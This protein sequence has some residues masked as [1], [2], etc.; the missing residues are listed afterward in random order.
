M[1]NHYLFT[2]ITLVFFALL[3]C[4]ATSNSTTGTTNAKPTGSGIAG[5]TSGMKKY[6]G[7]FEFYYDGKTDKVYLLVDKFDQEFIYV[8][9]LAA[10]IGSND[11]G[12][13]RNQLGN[14]RVVKFERVGPKILLVEPN[15]SYRAV[16]K[17]IAEQKAVE[18]A[19]AKSI[20]YGFKM[21][22]EEDGKVLVDATDFFM[23]DAHNVT[24]RLKRAQQ[25]N[26]S[27]KKDLS[28]FYLEKTKNFPENS[29]FEVTLTFTGT[30][31]GGYIRSV[32]PT[33][34]NI[35]VRM[36]HSFVK[37]PDGNYEP[38]RF[39]PRAGFFGVSYYDYA[40]PI[41]EDIE[42]KFIARHR[43][44]KKDP[45]AEMSEAIEPIVYYLDPGTPEPIKSALVEG[46]GWWN[47]AFEAAGY[48]NAFQVKVLPEG[49]DP[50]DVRYNVINWVHR[51]TRGWSY[52]SSVTDPRTGEIIK[53]HVLLG[54]LRVRQ[55]FLIAEALLAPYE[56]GT[57]VPPEMEQMAL[58]RLRQ[59]AAHEVGHTLG[60]AHSYASSAENRASV[61]DYPHP[62][63]NLKEGKI[64][65]SGAYDNKIGEWD[66]VAIT[67][68][69]KN[70]EEGED[71]GQALDDI[72][73]DSFKKG[74]SFLSDQDARPQGGAHPYAHLWD[75]GK[76]AS[77]ELKRV[78]EIR[79]IALAKFG[80]NN[81]RTGDAYASLE[82]V[83]VPLYFFHRYQT[84]AAVK[85]MGGLNYRYALRGDGQLITEIVSAEEQ[86]KALDALLTTISSEQL[87]L[88]ESILQ[89]IPP[90]PLYSSR[91][92]ELTEIRTG[93][94][95]DAI[96]AAESAA[97]MTLSLLFHPARAQRLVEYKAR[98][99]DRPGL[100]DVIDEL[101]NFTWKKPHDN[102]LRGEIERSVD[103]LVLAQ[104]FKLAKNK[105][106]S[107]QVQAIA[108]SKIAGLKKWLTS[109]R[110]SA[111]PQQAH[112]QYALHK[113]DQFLE[114]PMEYE[115][116]ETFDPPA[117]S[118]IGCGF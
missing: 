97:N 90:R 80:Q 102:S 81:I 54:S 96:G 17:N 99:N 71:E 85:L 4:A 32:A 65:L 35:T 40:V 77:D 48:K 51:S 74:L 27:L 82:E 87:A 93:L 68:G 7:F 9:S 95:F 8:N 23:A 88:P 21:V 20:L 66:K 84:E 52:G 10:G 3:G 91:T 29:E 79:K 41:S 101:I 114:N 61:M 58:A 69:Y 49:A 31:T 18:D 30:P 34:T 109:A 16:S 60:L 83:L 67:Y 44:K 107:E 106:A 39:D 73:S 117:G 25:G 42:K 55:D 70:F 115:P 12:L 38:R 50:L 37:L 45:S 2:L 62:V 76:D 22:T 43:L 24:G 116:T 64:D 100:D 78:L 104:L 75:N 28:A 118:P 14:T 103:D 36:H 53:G 11:I 26:Y 6:E 56:D 33:P 86:Q 63:A 92:R 98:H 57:T 110:G 89:L 108:F 1:K 72:I 15:Y 5:K 112:Y 105:R 59:L 13:D 111:V 47:Q 94:T 113:I 19:F 46:A